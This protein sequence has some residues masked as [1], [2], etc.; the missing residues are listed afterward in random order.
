VFHRCVRCNNWVDET[1][2]NKARGLVRQLRA[3]PRG[4]DGGRAL[5]GRSLTDARRGPATTVFSGDT[6]TRSTECPSCGKPVG[7]E[8]FCANCGTPLGVASAP[9]AEPNSP[10]TL[11]SAATAQQGRLGRLSRVASP[12]ISLR[13]SSRRSCRNAPQPER[14]ATT[15]ARSGRLEHR[16]CRFGVQGGRGAGAGCVAVEPAAGVPSVGACAIV[17]G[18]PGRRRSLLKRGRPA[19]GRSTRRRMRG[20]RSRQGPRRSCGRSDNA[21]ARRDRPAHRTGTRHGPVDELAA[22]RARVLV[23]RHLLRSCQ[24]GMP[25]G[26]ESIDVAPGS[27]AD[28]A[29]SASASPPA[30]ETS[31]S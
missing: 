6:S 23:S 11:A 27:P 3:Q 4:R 8:K 13:P 31:A 1:C 28:S 2:F 20:T 24:P 12:R 7:S 19:A 14:S 17:A 16:R 25:E 22:I 10:P 29:S 18:F 26:F 30:A 21:S 5:V 15:A 9:S